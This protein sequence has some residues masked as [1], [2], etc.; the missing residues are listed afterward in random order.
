MD[1][2][3]ADLCDKYDDKVQVLGVGFNSYGGATK[4]SGKIAT[5]KLIDN[6]AELIKLLKSEGH[7]RVCVVDVDAKY[8]AV[9]G[10]KLMGFAKEN[11]WAGIIV[12]GYVRDI[13]T[14]KDITV[15]LIALGTCPKKA[16]IQNSG[17]TNVNLFFADVKFV[18]N[19]YLYADVDGV[20]TSKEALE[21]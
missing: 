9:V 18:E 12:N 7:G 14:T 8:V 11:N 6:N 20:I 10:D 3:T 19:E 5:C 2:F 15:G 21:M 4:F 1:F 17:K 16:P 13:G